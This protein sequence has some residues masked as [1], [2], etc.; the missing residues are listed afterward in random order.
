MT[1]PVNKKED[2]HFIPSLDGIRALAVL[3]V[4]VSHSG[5]SYIIPGGF[6]VTVFFFL[7]GYLITTLLRKEHEKTGGISLKNFYLRR[8]YRIFPPMYLVLLLAIILSVFGF[9]EEAGSIDGSSVI[10]QIFHLTNYYSLWYGDGGFP[11]G[12]GILWSLAVEE[13]FYLLYPI[14]LIT[15]LKCAESNRK[16]VNILL[17]VCILV[18][19][20]RCFLVQYAGVS[21]EYTYRATDT[22]IDSLLWGCMLGLVF[23][24]S[25]DK[26]KLLPTRISEYVFLAASIAVLGYCFYNRDPYFRETFRYTLQGIALFPLFYLCIKNSSWLIFRPLNHPLMVW[27]GRLSYTI[28]L[29]HI[30]FLDLAE[31]FIQTNLLARGILGALFTLIFSLLMYHLVE[32]RFV[33]MRI[34]LHG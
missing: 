7:S 14:A 15:L 3:T 20:W 8:V 23:N 12:T 1:L 16:I 32:K 21:D 2:G 11:I 30:I 26:E 9:K 13:H 25:M 29:S 27:L 18:L 10:A 22:R 6:G 17:A 24:P 28:Y 34:K 5:F 4:F 31:K 19:A 33:R